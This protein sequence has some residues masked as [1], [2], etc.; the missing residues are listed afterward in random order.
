MIDDGD[1]GDAHQAYH[2]HL[3]DMREKDAFDQAQEDCSFAAAVAVVSDYLQ[4]RSNI[5]RE[6]TLD[7]LFRLAGC[8]E[9]EHEAIE[10]LNGSIPDPFN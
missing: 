9:Q 6:S 8:E 3:N 1:D 2:Q 7:I 4:E 10:S 5:P